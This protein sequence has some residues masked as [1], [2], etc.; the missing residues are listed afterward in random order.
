MGFKPRN[1]RV[2]VKWTDAAGYH[3]WQSL[4]FRPGPAPCETIGYLVER[5][6]EYITVAHTMS[7]EGMA[8]VV[9]IPKRC[10]ISVGR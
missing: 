8:D 7:D 10:L 9:V 6:D 5:T 2:R 4:D 1:R 3:G